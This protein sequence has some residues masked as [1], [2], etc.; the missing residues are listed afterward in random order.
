MKRFSKFFAL[1]LAMV[2]T[3]GMTV[4]AAPSTGEDAAWQEKVEAA[5]ESAKK[6]TTLMYVPTD[7]GITV[8]G[9]TV[10]V[11][12]EIAPL[13]GEEY[14][15]AESKVVTKTDAIQTALK[16]AGVKV[17]D[18]APQFIGAVNI[19][20]DLT[21]EQWAQGVRIPLTVPGGVKSNMKY[22]VLHDGE[23]IVAAPGVD[24]IYVTVKHNSTFVITAQEVQTV[25]DNGANDEYYNNRPYNNPTKSPQ[26]GE[27]LPMAAIMAMICLAGAAVC[28]R[29]AA[30]NK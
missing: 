13:D 17:A 9:K 23:V 29:K 8:D 12:V 26:T 14:L 4:S 19:E 20:L 30:Y 3:F 22:V 10:D 6:D 15:A 1:G 16:D 7:R 28:V 24:I 11:K 2:M 21:A 5:E 25:G 27:T 18:K